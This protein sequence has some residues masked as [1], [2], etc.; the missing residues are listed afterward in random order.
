MINVREYNLD[1]F[2]VTETEAGLDYSPK[3]NME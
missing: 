3:S 2:I 1:L